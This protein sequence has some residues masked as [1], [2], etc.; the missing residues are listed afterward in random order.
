LLILENIFASV[1]QFSEGEK[2]RTS[3]SE[4]LSTKNKL[5]MHITYIAR[6]VHRNKLN[7]NAILKAYYT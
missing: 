5:P 3:E 2:Q 7:K 4:E 1:V 6:K